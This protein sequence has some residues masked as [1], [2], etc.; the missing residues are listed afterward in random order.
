MSLEVEM[1]VIGEASPDYVQWLDI[2]N[3]DI[4]CVQIVQ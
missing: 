2:R 4:R 1:I 3:G